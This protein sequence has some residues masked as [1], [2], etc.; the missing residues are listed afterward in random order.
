M[1]GGLTIR[2]ST[3]KKQFGLLKNV[4]IVP[5]AVGTFNKFLFEGIDSVS[6]D[7]SDSADDT[8]HIDGG[9]G[10]RGVLLRTDTGEVA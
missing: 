4:K 1:P 2:S 9:T 6:S 10:L 8:R 5:V 3:C 7:N